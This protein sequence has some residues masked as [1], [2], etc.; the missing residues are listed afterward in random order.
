[1]SGVPLSSRHP[2][3]VVWESK[4]STQKV[5]SETSYKPSWC[6]ETSYKTSEGATAGRASVV[7]SSQHTDPNQVSARRTDQGATSKKL[8]SHSFERG[9]ARRSLNYSSA[10]SRAEDSERII[11]ELRREIYDLRQEA[12]SQSP[13]KER[14]RNR[15]IA[16]KRKNPEHSTLSLNSRDEDF[17]KTFGSQSESKSLTPLTVPKKPLESRGHS[18]SCLPLHGEKSPRTKEQSIRK[19]ARPGGQNAIWRALDLVSSFPFS[20]EIEKAKLPERYTAPRFEAYNSQT[21]P[22]AHIGHYQQSMTL[23]HYNDP[24]ICWLF[25]SSLGEV[26]MRWFN[27]LGRQTI[28]SWD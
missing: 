12:R 26:A 27:Q 17:S 28:N 5:S 24:F 8:G 22:M 6:T 3:F 16:L 20:R 25:P 13:A 19:I 9:N 21:D 11:S 18:R 23:S 14:P 10:T 7:A 1:M 2:R 4:S 15:V